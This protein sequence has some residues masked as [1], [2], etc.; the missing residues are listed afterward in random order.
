MGKLYGVLELLNTLIHSSVENIVNI[1]KDTLC[2]IQSCLRNAQEKIDFLQLESQLQQEELHQNRHHFE[3]VF[4]VE[5]YSVES[6][7]DTS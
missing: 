1:N 2:D 6:G 7:L 5:F 3:P 4:G